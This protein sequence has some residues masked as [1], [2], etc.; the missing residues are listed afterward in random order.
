MSEANDKLLSH[1][2]DGIQ[3][4]DN[5]LPRWWLWLF[6]LTIIWG[7]LY[8]VFYHVAHIGYLSADEYRQELDPNYVRAESR[9]EKFLGFMPRYH[10]PYY[11]PQR[12]LALSGKV[13]KRSLLGMK[14]E[15]RESDTT[16]YVALTDPPALDAGKATFLARCSSCH[17]KLGEGN[18]GPNLTDDYW[19]HGN[20]MINVTKTV[21]YGYPAKGMLSWRGE[22]TPDQ[23]MQVASYVLTLHGTNPPNPKPPQGDLVKQ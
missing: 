3:E 1:N 14:E 9:D 16:T 22:L 15:T 18:I 2:Y 10:P 19:I 4:F 20:G 17:G 12:D 7:V 8:F 13:Q 6:Y 21:K 5:D 23:I 11:D